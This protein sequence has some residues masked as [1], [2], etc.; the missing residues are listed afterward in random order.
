VKWD[1]RVTK[2]STEV[3]RKLVIDTEAKFLQEQHIRKALHNALIEL[4][5]N[6]LTSI[7]SHFVSHIELATYTRVL[8]D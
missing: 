3:L 2:H 1:N 5:G 8:Q 6:I 4:R 7:V